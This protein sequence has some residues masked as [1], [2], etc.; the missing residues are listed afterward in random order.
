MV[1][2]NENHFENL[3]KQN[4]DAY[5]DFEKTLKIKLDENKAEISRLIESERQRIKEIVG[6]EMSKIKNLILIFG[7]LT[8]VL[9]IGI[10]AI[11]LM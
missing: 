5:I 3:R 8:V 4:R 2:S 10:L 6:I 11:Q 9:L 1:Q 7:V